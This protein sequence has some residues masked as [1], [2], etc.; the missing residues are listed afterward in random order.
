MPVASRFVSNS[1]T[2]QGMSFAGSAAN[3]TLSAMYWNPAAVANLD[4]FNSENHAAIILGDSEITVTDG[5]LVN[6]I[7]GVIDPNPLSTGDSSGN[8]AKPA[9]C[10]I[11]LLQLSAQEH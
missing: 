2:S 4:G 9:V 5:T 10:A 6:G 7:G 1:T 8:I 3:S 11:E